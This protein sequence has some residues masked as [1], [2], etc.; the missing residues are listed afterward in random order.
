MSKNELS[1]KDGY[2]SLKKN[3]APAGISGRTRHRQPDEDCGR[4]ND[5]LQGMQVTGGCCTAGI[6]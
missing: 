2:E 6:K 4:V 3:A 5:R 1:F